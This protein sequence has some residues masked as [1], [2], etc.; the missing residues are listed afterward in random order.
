MRLS[1]TIYYVTIVLILVAVALIITTVVT[2]NPIWAWVGAG[3]AV[4]NAALGFWNSARLTRLAQH[5]RK[6]N[7]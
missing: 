7:A 6:D 2:W 5:Q 3:I 4:A 1:L